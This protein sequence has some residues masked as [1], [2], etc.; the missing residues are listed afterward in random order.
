MR[1]HRYHVGQVIT[2]TE[3]DLTVT[4]RLV[5]ISK[6]GLTTT[7]GD[8]NGTADPWHVPTRQ[9]IGEVVAAP[10]YVGFVLIYLKNPIGLASLAIVVFLWWQIWSLTEKEPLHSR[11]HSRAVIT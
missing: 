5:S 10:R 8:A 11:R 2:F 6:D 4:H 1:E 7:K 9:I 3:G